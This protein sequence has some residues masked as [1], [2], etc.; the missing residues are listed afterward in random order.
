MLL[1]LVVFN[2]F[3]RFSKAALCRKF[4]ISMGKNDRL[5]GLFHPA[6]LARVVSWLVFV[7]R[8]F[9]GHNGITRPRT[10]KTG[11]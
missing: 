7:C 8:H 11:P 10:N 2:R 3:C 4:T 1:L 9:H 5:K 6:F